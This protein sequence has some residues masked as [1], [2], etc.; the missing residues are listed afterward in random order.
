MVPGQTLGKETDS[1]RTS[2]VAQTRVSVD[3]RNTNCLRECDLRST[4]NSLCRGPMLGNSTAYSSDALSTFAE[5]PKTGEEQPG[6]S[7]ISLIVSTLRNKRQIFFVSL[8]NN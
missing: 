4:I 3:L 2:F 7:G 5:E 1:E 8:L 6:P